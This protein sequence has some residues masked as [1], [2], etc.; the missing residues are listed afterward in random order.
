MS[1]SLCDFFFSVAISPSGNF[2]CL[3]FQ[4]VSVCVSVSVCLAEVELK[5]EFIRTLW[6]M[7]R[8]QKHVHLYYEF[9]ARQALHSEVS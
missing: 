4:C 6:P 1:L 7:L 9:E 3:G 2:T 5:L 8:K